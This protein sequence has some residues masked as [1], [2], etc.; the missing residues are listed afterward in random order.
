[1]LKYLLTHSGISNR[2][3]DNLDLLHMVWKAQAYRE[4][5][6]QWVRAHVG[7]PQND[8]VDRLAYQAARRD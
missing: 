8:V 5:E 7:N 1:M 4:V 3:A 2:K 6:Y